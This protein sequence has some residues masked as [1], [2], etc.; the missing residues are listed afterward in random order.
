MIMMRDDDNKKNEYTSG[1]FANK[2]NTND[3]SAAHSLMR[4]FQEIKL[5]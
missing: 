2:Y 3:V 5:I 4:L 1:M